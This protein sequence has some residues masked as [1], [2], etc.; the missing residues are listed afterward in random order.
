MSIEVPPH[1]T[2]LVDQDLS[3]L[4]DLVQLA[5]DHRDAECH[6]L[7]PCGGILLAEQIGELDCGMRVVLLQ[8]AVVELAALG[9]GIPT[10]ADAYQVTEAAA[11]VL[12]EDGGEQH[13]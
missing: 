6:W 7:L 10:A 8:L 9:Y 2:A 13:G 3:A 11:A 4:R 1:L 12:D 5:R